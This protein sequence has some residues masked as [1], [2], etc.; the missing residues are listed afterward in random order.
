MLVDTCYLPVYQESEEWIN[1]W[2]LCVSITNVIFVDSHILRS[3][4]LTVLVC[5]I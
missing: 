4:M 2:I 5:Q 1:A 3:E